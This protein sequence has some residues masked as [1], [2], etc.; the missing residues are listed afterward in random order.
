MKVVLR[1]GDIK[2]A[3]LEEMEVKEA[4]WHTSAHVLVQ[5]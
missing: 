1:N 3:S 2:E 5:I 4:F